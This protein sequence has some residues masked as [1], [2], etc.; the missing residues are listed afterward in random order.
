M[1]VFDK[2]TDVE[3]YR[4]WT[5]LQK[6]LVMI[7][8]PFGSFIEVL[9]KQPSSSYFRNLLRESQSRLKKLFE[10]GEYFL[11]IISDQAFFLNR[12]PLMQWGYFQAIQR[13]AT[14]D[15]GKKIKNTTI[16]DITP[17]LTDA[18]HHFCI[19]YDVLIHNFRRFIHAIRASEVPVTDLHRSQIRPFLDLLI[20]PTD[21]WN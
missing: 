2:R 1:K 14:D 4:N 11:V 6:K 7:H 17:I 10:N 21:Y 13:Y 5:S 8:Q 9:P 15:E 16:V 3:A 12:L 20:P 19:D 18:K